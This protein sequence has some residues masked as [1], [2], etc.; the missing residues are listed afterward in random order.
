MQHSF[1]ILIAALMSASIDAGLGLPIFQLAEP[2][3][4]GI[5]FADFK[6]RRAHYPALST[7]PIDTAQVSAAGH[8]SRMSETG[9]ERLPVDQ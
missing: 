7:P 6:L 1:A 9:V 4:I 8:L 3:L 5:S 2:M